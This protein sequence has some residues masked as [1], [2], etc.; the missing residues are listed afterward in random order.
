MEQVRLARLNMNSDHVFVS[1]ITYWLGSIVR[2]QSK[3]HVRPNSV[4]VRVAILLLEGHVDQALKVKEPNS[5]ST[6]LERKMAKCW[7]WMG[8]QGSTRSALIC[9]WSDSDCLFYVMHGSMVVAKSTILH[10]PWL[11]LLAFGPGKSMFP[12]IDIFCHPSFHLISLGG[13]VKWT[14]KAKEWRGQCKISV[15]ASTGRIFAVKVSLLEVRNQPSCLACNSTRQNIEA[16]SCF[17][18]KKLTKRTK[19]LWQNCQEKNI[20]DRYIYKKMRISH[21]F[22]EASQ[23]T[24]AS[25]SKWL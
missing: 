5:G 20:I 16:R 15:K 18:R 19:T 24:W 8:H 14:F 2:M 21:V 7:W 10:L 17:S 1:H 4:P 9:F 12:W 11:N 13:S 23:S 25:I 6:L 3:H 22:G